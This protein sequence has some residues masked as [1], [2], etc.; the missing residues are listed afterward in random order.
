MAKLGGIDSTTVNAAGNK[1]TIKLDLFSMRERFTLL[2][3][4]REQ[5][6]IIDSAKVSSTLSVI[7]L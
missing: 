2:C 1:V 7:I 4:P 3:P 6:A 5:N